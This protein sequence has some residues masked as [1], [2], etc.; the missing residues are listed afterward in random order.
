MYD[1]FDR[2]LN[3]HL[4]SYSKKEQGSLGRKN[5]RCIIDSKGFQKIDDKTCTWS[6]A[7]KCKMTVGYLNK[8]T[9]L[10]G[11]EVK[12]KLSVLKSVCITNNWI[13]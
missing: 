3:T 7:Y 10:D 6:A 2:V 5:P 13:L 9:K 4:A 12:L 11:R 8:G 1:L